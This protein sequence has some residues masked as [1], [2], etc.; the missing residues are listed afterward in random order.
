M[1][2][3]LYYVVLVFLLFLP[4]KLFAYTS[5]GVCLHPLEQ[6]AL[7]HGNSKKKSLSSRLDE[8][9]K[10]IE[11]LREEKN[12]LENGD[13]EGFDSGIEGLKENL[14]S[15]LKGDFGDLKSDNSGTALDAVELIAQYIQEKQD[16]WE[17]MPEEGEPLAQKVPWANDSEALKRNG[18]VV[19]KKFCPNYSNNKKECKR[20]VEDLIEAYEEV[21]LI[22]E[23]IEEQEELFRELRKRE[24]DIRLGLTDEEDTEA[25]GLC[26][27]CLDELRE[28]DKPTS[29]QTLG[30]ILSVVAGGAMSYYGYQAGK[31]WTRNVN[32]MRLTQGYDPLSSAGASWAGASLGL[33]FISNGIYGLAGGNSQFGNY[34]CSNGFANRNSMYSPFGNMAGYGQMGGGFGNPY[35]GG[36]GNPYGGGFWQPFGGRFGKGGR[37]QSF[38]RNGRSFWRIR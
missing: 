17:D 3:V 13:D 20:S 4:G 31:R 27:D 24:R 16:K 9:K 35:G 37:R 21:A 34:A 2:K 6:A 8:I 22:D 12:I 23:L 14:A 1:F 33:P 25:S 32:N 7:F 29:G 36:F 11:T 26:W 15:T 19:H 10:H 28:L 18:K 5:G 30:S 38:W